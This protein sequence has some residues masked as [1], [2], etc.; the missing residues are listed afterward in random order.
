MKKYIVKSFFSEKDKKI[1]DVILEYINVFCI[2]D[3]MSLR[4]NG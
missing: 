3:I 1:E 2:K 4:D